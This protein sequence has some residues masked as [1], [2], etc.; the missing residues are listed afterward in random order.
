MLSL[1][2]VE[3]DLSSLL[4]DIMSFGSLHFRSKLAQHTLNLES[5]RLLFK[6]PSRA[7]SVAR[8]VTPSISSGEEEPTALQVLVLLVQES[9]RRRKDMKKVISIEGEKWKTLIQSVKQV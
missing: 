7:S 3:L 1:P 5:G 2:R 9:K 4:F 6:L 8:G